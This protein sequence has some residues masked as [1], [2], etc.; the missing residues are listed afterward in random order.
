[1]KEGLKEKVINGGKSNS[2]MDDKRNR[3]ERNGRDEG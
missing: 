2:Q 1:M 3:E